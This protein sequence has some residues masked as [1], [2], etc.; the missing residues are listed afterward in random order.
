MWSADD[1]RVLVFGQGGGAVLDAKTGKA[2]IGATGWAFGLSN[3]YPT[4]FPPGVEPAI[5]FE[6]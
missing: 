1:A 4:A 2:L 6:F 5:R 3:E